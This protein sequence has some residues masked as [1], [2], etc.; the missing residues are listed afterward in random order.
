MSEEPKPR[1]KR[2]TRAEQR[3]RAKEASRLLEEGLSRR[4]VAKRLGYPNESAVYQSVRRYRLRHRVRVDTGWVKVSRSTGGTTRLALCTNPI[5]RAGWK[6]GTLVRWAVADGRILLHAAER[7]DATVAGHD[8]ADPD[9]VAFF[10]HRVRG[11]TISDVARELGVS[12]SEAHRMVVRHARSHP[13]L[14]AHTR[15][16][17]ADEGVVQVARRGSGLALLL[18]SAAQRVGWGTSD[19]V[20]WDYDRKT[21]VLR[22]TLETSASQA[23]G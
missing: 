8:P 9:S 23:A 13:W 4:L 18:V 19:I 3:Q 16:P 7:I 2:G 10:L 17:N 22:L 14:L 15:S 21:R 1:R 5:R 11:R 20:R 6:H 12:R